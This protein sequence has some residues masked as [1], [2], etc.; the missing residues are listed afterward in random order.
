MVNNGLLN[1]DSF[2][3][4]KSLQIRNQ[5][6]NID[7]SAIP[8]SEAVS[9]KLAYRDVY[10]G[11]RVAME[12]TGNWMIGEAGGSDKIPATFKTGI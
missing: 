7:K 9:Q 12:A 6:E 5:A 2:T 11:K 3:V 10:F 1:V 4:R 8:F